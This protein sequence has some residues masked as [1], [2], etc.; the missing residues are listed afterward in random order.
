MNQK[1]VTSTLQ[2]VA[3]SVLTA[4]VVFGV[5]D[6]EEGNALAGVAV[7]L[8]PL[9]AAVCIRSARAPK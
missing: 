9:F 2:G 4:L 1:Q 8:V 5:L 6:A 3:A 7:S